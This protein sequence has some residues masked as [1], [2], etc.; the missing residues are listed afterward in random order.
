[1]SGAEFVVPEAGASG[2]VPA[3]ASDPTCRSVDVG[4]V[5]GKLKAF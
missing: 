1:V 2:L 3:P 4:L 5:S